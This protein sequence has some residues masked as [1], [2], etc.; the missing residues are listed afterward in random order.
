MAS[1]AFLAWVRRSPCGCERQNTGGVGF[2]SVTLLKNSKANLRPAIA[3][4][5]RELERLS[6]SCSVL[7]SHAPPVVTTLRLKT[8]RDSSWRVR[9]QVRAQLSTLTTMTI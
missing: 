1:F 2:S 9:M 3:K 8:Q 7:A 5:S 6:G 4:I